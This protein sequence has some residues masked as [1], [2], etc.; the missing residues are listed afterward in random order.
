[1]L[2][3]WKWQ[4]DNLCPLCKTPEDAPHVWA[5]RSTSS[6]AV[7][8]VSI[9]KL[10]DW[11]VETR[12]YPHLRQAIC[13]C[14]LSWKKALPTPSI[15]PSAYPTLHAAVEDQAGIGWSAFIE[16]RLSTYWAETQQQYFTAINSK[17][18]GH[19]WVSALI[20]KLFEVAWDQWEHRCGVVHNQEATAHQL[21]IN[22]AVEDTL[23]SGPGKLTGR[24]RRY[25][26][27]PARVRALPTSSKEGWLLNVEAAFRRQAA[28]DEQL[29]QG[30]Q[31]QR[32][33]MHRWLAKA[34][35]TR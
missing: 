23:T 3:K 9:K 28:R 14:L 21:C 18:T 35:L 33:L 12:A 5:C 29:R 6:I 10:S 19:R 26:L 25:F 32:A 22:L 15:L 31:A 30:Q 2:K 27:F 34:E 17:K 11:M 1:M 13:G 24:D 20:K 16:G 4:D 8:E 7:W